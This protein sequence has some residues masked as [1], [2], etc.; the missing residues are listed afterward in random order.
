MK[1]VLH[2]IGTRNGWGIANRARYLSDALADRWSMTTGL[3]EDEV[4]MGRLKD[5]DIV[6]LHSMVYVPILTAKLKGHPAWGFEIVSHR[7]LPRF[8]WEKKAWSE[9]AF[10]VAKNP[11]LADEARPYLSV[12]PSIIPNGVATGIFRPRP[13]RIGWVGRRDDPR[14][15][16]YKGVPLIEEAVRAFDASLRAE[17]F[18]SAELVFDPGDYPRVASHEAMADWYRTLDAVVCASEAE[19]CS[20]VLL[21]ALAVGLPVLTTD[22]GIARDLEEKAGAVIVGRSAERIGAG[23]AFL[24]ENEIRRRAAV[25]EHWSW[26]VVADRYDALYMEVLCAET[27]DG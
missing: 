9:A 25:L 24:F 7:S 27:A 10:C 20:N 3:I 1:K 6:H 2:V 19:G 16:D 22:C 5:F 17:G 21:E 15:L 11:Q 26:S 18:G 4:I 23:L 13:F 8:S 12:E 14:R